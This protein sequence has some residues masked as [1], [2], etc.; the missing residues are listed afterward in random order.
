MADLVGRYLHAV[1]TLLP[2][3]QREDIL[4]ELREDI[5][6][7]LEERE[8]ELGRPLS[9]GEIS[10]ILKKRGH[11]SM[12]ASRYLPARYLIGPALY[13]LY[14]FV[15]RLVLLWVIIPGFALAAPIIYATSGDSAAAMLDVLT[16][17]PSAL[18]SAFGAITLV[19]V[20]IERSWIPGM[21]PAWSDWDPRTL[22]HVPTLPPSD[23]VPR[24]A[25][26]GE[27]ISGIFWTGVWL[28]LAG[29]G[30]SV[31]FA[32]V[33]CS[34]PAVWRGLFWPQ[35]ILLLAGIALAGIVAFK[36]E[37]ARVYSTVRIVIDC[38]GLIIA[39]MLLRAG[40]AVTAAAPQFSTEKL[41]QVQNGIRLGLR[42]SLISIAALL[43]V[44]MLLQITRL[45]PGRSKPAWEMKSALGG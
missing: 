11:P 24:S 15:L 19:F 44:D 3:E 6:S 22:P 37:R 31:D 2:S 26:I 23:R 28:Y 4:A 34:L 17:L 36:P 20:A 40:T 1:R 41:A 16:K 5:R 29:N 18:F 38:G 35:L 10:E 42:V 39:T 43:L 8:G 25:S 7:Q 27:L 13:P 9:E 45:R 32:N 21:R 14:L 30:F 33:H 12:V